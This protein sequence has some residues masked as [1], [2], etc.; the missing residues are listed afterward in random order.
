VSVGENSYHDRFRPGKRASQMASNILYD[1]NHK[2]YSVAYQINEY[3][4]KFSSSQWVRVRVCFKE[5]LPRLVSSLLREVKRVM[6]VEHCVIFLV[7]ILL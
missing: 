6:R 1:R 3:I 2:N 7:I 4:M 5:K